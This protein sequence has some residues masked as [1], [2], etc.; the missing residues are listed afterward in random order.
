MEAIVGGV[1]VFMGGMTFMMLVQRNRQFFVTLGTG[2]Q[3]APGATCFALTLLGVT[4]VLTLQYFVSVRRTPLPYG[5][6]RGA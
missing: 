6:A 1:A 2:I 4:A 5:A 3:W